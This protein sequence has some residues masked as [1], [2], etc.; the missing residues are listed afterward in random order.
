M[1]IKWIKFYLISWMALF[2][3]ATA[4]TEKMPVDNPD[5]ITIPSLSEEEY[6]QVSKHILD[7]ITALKSEY[8]T[9]NNLTSPQNYEY[10]VTWVLEDPTKP[11]GKT[12]A[13]L[14]VYGEDGFWFRLTFYRAEYQG[15]AKFSPIEFGDLK[16]W[17]QYGH[18][19]NTKEIAA[20][21]SI[22]REENEAFCKKHPW[23]KN[24]E[25]LMKTAVTK[26]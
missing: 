18:N 21:T 17:F 1:T 8:P 11:H 12:N 16:L 20:I 7:R 4:Q 6:N 26:P 22:L 15:A 10:N 23:Q 2:E 9:L 24:N 14:E 25:S 13:R 5:A 3:C 19:G